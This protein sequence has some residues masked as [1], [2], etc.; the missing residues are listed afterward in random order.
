MSHLAKELFCDTID[1]KPAPSS[2]QRQR[3]SEADSFGNFGML[4]A[5]EA[6]RMVIPRHQTGR[7]KA[8][9]QGEV[10]RLRLCQPPA[11][12]EGLGSLT[13]NGLHTCLGL[14]QAIELLEMVLKM[15]TTTY[16]KL[17]QIS[18]MTP[19]YGDNPNE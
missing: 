12:V 6:A 18:V 15:A 13:T 4:P 9:A 3:V 5:C 16:P 10:L 2:S 14:L 11:L 1:S 7:K 8:V 19:I 17:Q